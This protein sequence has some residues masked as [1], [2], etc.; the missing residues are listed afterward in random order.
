[1]IKIDF[2]GSTHGHFL[3]YVA[4]V[5][6]MQTAPSKTNIFKKD[7]GS[8]HA[9]DH[10]YLNN[11][12][13]KCGHFSSNGLPI[14]ITDKVIRIVLNTND[15]DMFFIALTNLIYKAN[16]IGFE[17]QVLSI[18]EEIRNNPVNYR[19]N[20]YSK[21]N[22]RE[23]YHNHYKEFKNI[24]NNIFKFDFSSFFFFDKLCR[25]LNCLAL[26]LEQTFF[27]DESLRSLWEEFIERNQ[28]WQSYIKCSK[29]IKDIFG[30]NSTDLTDCTIIEQ[31]WINY[32]LSNICRLF[33]GTM[34]S[35]THYPTNTKEIYKEI[36]NHL[37]ILRTA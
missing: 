24:P 36:Q 14:P 6:I 11:R 1:M 5:Y 26:F 10:T 13:I 19:N 8:A 27:P 21:F 16:D 12:I 4:N 34:F 9:V 20:W 35:N 18:P 32:N 22:E 28:G 30:N 23:I 17:K 31:G 29:I 37:M 3:E 15:S 33:E 2:H 7:T 25:E